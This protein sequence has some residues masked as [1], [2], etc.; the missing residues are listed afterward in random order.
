MTKQI[1]SRRSF[2]RASVAAGG[3]LMLGFHMP[4]ALAASI[5]P[6]TQSTTTAVGTEINAWI[7]IDKDGT[8]TLR[9]PHT[10]QGQGGITSVA[11]L[12]AEELNV[13]WSKIK[14]E[15]ADANRHLR[16]NKEYKVMSTHGSQ[17]VRLQHPHLMGAGASARERLKQA[18]AEAW[19]VDRSEIEAKLG[20]LTAGNRTATY[21]E[22]AAAAARVKL[23][24]EPEIQTDP[25]KWWLLGK[26]RQRLDIPNKVNGSA[27][28]AIDTRLPGMVYAAV[29][30]SPVP[31]GT[32]K[33]YNFD[34]IKDRPG[35]LAAVRLKAVPGKRGQP[36][37]QDAVAVVADSW[38]RAKT[39]LELLPIEW[40]SGESANTS[41]A[42]YVA[43]GRRLVDQKGILSGKEDSMA[44]EIIASAKKRVTATY[45]RPF[46]T[47]ARMEPINATVHVQPDRVDVWS[48]TQDQSAAITLVADQLGVDPK[49]V[50][51]HTMFLGG[52]FGGNGGGGTGVTRQA[53][54]IS[55][56]IGK[57]VKVIWS[58][59]E[60]I[61]QDKQRPLTV[62]KLTAAIGDDGLPTALFTRAAWVTFD[63]TNQWGSATADYAIYNMPYKFPHRQHERHNIKTHVPGSTHR[64]PGANQHGFM[65]ESFIDEIAIAGGWDPLEWR[66]KMTEGLDDWQLVLRTLKE[67]SGFRTDLPKGEGM[68]VAVVESHGTIAAACA[69]VNVSR[70]GRLTIEKIL[71]VMDAGRVINPHAATEQCE[72][73]VV[74]ELS[75]AWMGGLELEEGRFVNT[76]FDTY[77][78]LRIDQIPQVETIF[79]SSGGAKW[80]GLGEPAGPPAPPAVANAIYYATGGGAV[81]QPGS[82]LD[83]LGVA[84]FPTPKLP[85]HRARVSRALRSMER[86]GMMRCRPGTVTHTVFATVP[87]QRCTASLWLA[88][89]RIRDT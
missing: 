38:Y 77:N 14:T 84:G 10:E 26:P 22:F 66:I 80:G 74:W 83:R 40:E 9:I 54:E 7:V 72:G 89:H 25:A 63:G 57:P 31:W 58:R 41:S 59:E 33:S 46:E 64:A 79:A 51:A 71:V 1:L 6:R 36:D 21:G 20:V 23:D 56:Q 85:R 2:I 88:L 19:G 18:A 8:V 28:Y 37:M 50:Y 81:P 82:D 52:G 48:P 53:A 47:H 44:A 24:K 39:A 34:V 17:L 43:E 67:K 27:Q 35:V 70:R 16:N 12:I 45:D 4:V 87:D 61:A 13:D 42:A 15:F 3:G 11:M 86:S 62:A 49:I 5:G 75:H 68:G 32:L 78:L 30:A 65:A 55:R 29:R 76:N 69:T 60:D 73:S